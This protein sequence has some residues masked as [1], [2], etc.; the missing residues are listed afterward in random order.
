MPPTT[1]QLPDDPQSAQEFQAQRQGGHIDCLNTL[2]VVIR[3]QGEERKEHPSENGIAS[4]NWDPSRILPSG[5]RTRNHRI[6]SMRLNLSSKKRLERKKNKGWKSLQF[7]KV[8]LLIMEGQARKTCKK[9]G[10]RQ[11]CNGKRKA[12]HRRRPRGT[13]APQGRNNHAATDT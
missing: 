13:T 2:L 1:L 9:E 5:R 3:E 6:P 10:E 8:V 7:V 12:I 4:R 11:S